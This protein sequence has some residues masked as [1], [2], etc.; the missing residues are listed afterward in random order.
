MSDHLIFIAQCSRIFSF[1]KRILSHVTRNLTKKVNRKQILI[2]QNLLI[3]NSSQFFQSFLADLNGLYQ[4]KNAAKICE[5]DP[6][7]G[8]FTFK[9]TPASSGPLSKMKYLTN[10][11]HFFPA[12]HFGKKRKPKKQFFH[13]TSYRVG[14]RNFVKL[15]NSYQKI[16]TSTYET[17]CLAKK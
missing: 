3:Y 14:S 5:A 9:G 7:C 4:P 12:E 11:F 8:G 13:W 1:L 2:Q 15:P 17:V 10:F 16:E 6:A